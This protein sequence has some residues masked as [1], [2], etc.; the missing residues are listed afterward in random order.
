MG[1]KHVAV[2]VTNVDDGKLAW[3][4]QHEQYRDVEDFALWFC[5]W[6]KVKGKTGLELY[7]LPN[8]ESDGAF[9]TGQLEKCKV[10]SKPL[11]RVG[12]GN[13][14]QV[15]A[16]IDAFGELFAKFVEMQPAD[17]YGI[18]VTGHGASKYVMGDLFDVKYSRPLFTKIREALG[19][20][21]LDF[22][23]AM[24]QCNAGSYVI[25]EQ[26]ATGVDYYLASALDVG[27]ID[28]KGEDLKAADQ[29]LMAAMNLRAESKYYQGFEN[30]P[31]KDGNP[32]NMKGCLIKLADMQRSYWAK[33]AEYKDDINMIS[34]NNMQEVAIYDCSKVAALRAALGW[35]PYNPDL[36]VSKFLNG[37]PPPTHKQCYA[38]GRS[39]YVD[40][41]S[42]VVENKL[43]TAKDALD[44][45]MVYY[46]SNEQFGV[47][48]PI[49]NKGTPATATSHGLNIHEAPWLM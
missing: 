33:C 24:T 13:K 42:Y 5:V 2:L 27:G 10:W 8:D 6:N 3:Y 14:E 18:K 35:N 46:T 11:D 48:W 39:M 37:A 49:N 25:L 30:K 29:K 28:K 9:D 45:V 15:Q 22:W 20:K 7:Q 16:Q 19:G 32:R 4:R 26:M 41:H 40:M 23:D 12:L 44:Q 21:N 17:H 38:V 36:Q 1:K 43:L 34:K 47:D 31:D